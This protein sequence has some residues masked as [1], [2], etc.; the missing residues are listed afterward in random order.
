MKLLNA[1]ALAGQLR[2]VGDCERFECQTLQFERPSIVIHKANQPDIALNF[3]VPD[4]LA[5]KDRA[6]I[7]FFCPTQMRQ[8]RVPTKAFPETWV[9]VL[10]GIPIFLHLQRTLPKKAL[11]D[12]YPATRPFS[13]GFGSIRC[14][15]LL[16]TISI[17]QSESA[18]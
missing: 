17:R 13:L 6:D 8:K 16:P 4:L 11:V 14:R 9:T 2:L 7:N 3:L 10:G 1:S 12:A 18:A 15:A 5:V